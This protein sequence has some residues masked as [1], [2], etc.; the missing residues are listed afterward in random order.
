MAFKIWARARIVHHDDDPALLARLEDP[1]CRAKA[2]LAVVLRIE[3]F[4]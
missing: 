4:D 1:S 2:E 3:A